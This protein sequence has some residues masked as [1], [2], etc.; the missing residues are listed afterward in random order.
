MIAGPGPWP[1]PLRIL[2]TG[3]YVPSRQIRSED[4]D[5]V[6]G[7]PA[8]TTLA[9][10]GV[11]V[12]RW[13][14]THETSSH[15]AAAALADAAVAGGVGLGELD[16]VLVGAVVPEQPM[17]TTAVL[18]LR[19]LGLGDGRVEAF[20]VNASCLGFLTALEIA[21]L[22]VAVGRWRTV[23]VAAVDVASKGLDHGDVESSSL[24]GD[25][26]G[27]AVVRRA[28]DG[29]GSGLLALRIG[30]WPEA[31]DL[32]RIDAGG[33][34]WN[35]TTPPPDARS[36]LF[37]MDG[38]GVL[39]QAAA[40]LPGV[41]AALFEDAG[42]TPDDVDVVVPHQASGVGLRY[43][44]EKLGFPAHAVVDVLGERGNQVAASLPVALHEAVASGR[45]RR[46][47]TALVLGT[48]AGLSVGAALVRY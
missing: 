14:D 21:A 15:M 37:R 3:A 43:L 35:T 45:L 9:A 38:R 25:G 22:G 5:A 42:L 48:A 18:T 24:F 6:H 46:G 16:A 44:R 2:G 8:G 34:R 40:R 28:A 30:C 29:E 33:T 12:R 23:G 17:P 10:S 4:L 31:A 47:G 41:L 39:K 26:A 27:A 11:R 32:C 20:D 1:L 13:A 36:Y 19:R 7:R